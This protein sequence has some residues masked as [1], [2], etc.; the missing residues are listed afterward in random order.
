MRV[1]DMLI[2]LAIF[3]V[4]FFGI[5]MMAER[6]DP[7]GTYRVPPVTVTPAEDAPGWDCWLHGDREC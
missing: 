4:L 7:W 1:R 3:G 5:R 6:P 2:L